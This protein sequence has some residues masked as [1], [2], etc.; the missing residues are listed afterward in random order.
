[1]F[2]YILEALSIKVYY[3]KEAAIKYGPIA[4]VGYFLAKVKHFQKDCLEKKFRTV[5]KL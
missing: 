5:K 3:D 1:M 2:R 4:C